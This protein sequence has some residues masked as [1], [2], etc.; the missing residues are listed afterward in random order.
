MI[1][2]TN[3]SN[4]NI[5]LIQP[6]DR[7]S[8]ASF[9]S[10]IEDI[11]N[12]V[13]GVS[14]LTSGAHFE[15]WT[16]ST[17]YQ[18]GD[19][20]RT[21]FLK[22]NQYLECLVGGTSGSSCPTD[23]IQGTRITDNDI[24]WVIKALG[25]VDTSTVSLWASNW[26]YVRGHI[27]M[28]NNCLYRCKT[29]H[30]SSSSFDLDASYWQEVKASVGLW[31]PLVY[32]YVDDI[33]V[34]DGLIYKNN[35]A[36]VS[37]STFSS[38]EEV[39]WELIGGAGGI[40]SWQSSETYNEGQLVINGGI[41]Y[42]VKSK[43]TSSSNFSADIANWDILNAGLNDW[44]TNVYYPVGIVVLANNKIYQCKSAHTSTTF[45]A[46]IANW[47]E[48]SGYRIVIDDWKA[49]TEY[50]VGDLCANDKKIYRC[51]IKHTSG[52]LFDSV[53][54][55]NWEEL[56]PT[57]NEIT[58][59][60]SN[61]SYN[62]KDIVI[63][64]NRLYRC[65]V[66]HTSSSAGF[67]QDISNWD[68]VSAQIPAWTTATYYGVGDIIQSDNVMY[69]CITAHTSTTDLAID[70]ANWT[71]FP[72]STAYIQDWESKA[73]YE[74]NQVIN[75]KG[76]LFRCV[77][78]NNDTNFTSTNW[79]KL[80][81]GDLSLWETKTA[82][83]LGDTVIY[84]KKL[85][86]CTVP[87]TS[88]DFQK[89]ISNWEEISATRI[90]DWAINTPYVSGDLVI[91]DK[92]IYRCTSVHVSNDFSKEVHNWELISAMPSVWVSQSPY[93][94]GDI[95]IVDG[96]LYYCKTA[97]TST[98]DIYT[99]MANWT[100]LSQDGT[101]EW[102]TKTYYFKNQLVTRDGTL[103]RANVSH[104]ST[105]FKADT[106]KWDNMQAQIQS[107]IPSKFYKKD[108]LV[109]QDNK[110]WK[111]KVDTDAKKFQMTK[112]FSNLGLLSYSSSVGSSGVH[113]FSTPHEDIK[114][115]GS[116]V[117]I[118]KL[119]ISLRSIF[120]M[121]WTQIDVYI[122]SDN[123]EY[124]FM[125]TAIIDTSTMTGSVVVDS[126]AQYIKLSAK[127]YHTTNMNGSAS[128][129]MSVSELDIYADGDWEQLYN[130]FPTLL[131]PWTSH[132]EY[133]QDELVYHENLVYRVKKGFTSGAN[134]D[135]T[136]LELLN[137]SYIEDWQPDKYY[138]KNQCVTKDDILLRSTVSHTS[139][140]TF[141]STEESQWEYILGGGNNG[142]SQWETAIKYKEGNVVL[143][144]NTPYISNT[145]HTS[146]TFADDF[147]KWDLTYSN[148][149]DWEPDVFYH[150][151]SLVVHNDAIFQANTPH[152]SSD[153][154]T[155]IGAVFQTTEP[156]GYDYTAISP[157]LVVVF[158]EET[159]L[160]GFLILQSEKT[161]TNGASLTTVDVDITDSN[162]V[163]KTVKVTVG[164]KL[165]V[166]EK[167]TS[168]KFKNPVGVN[169]SVTEYVNQT[170]LILVYGKDVSC[171]TSLINPNKIT[172]KQ[173][174]VLF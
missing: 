2:A 45:T 166:T 128:G 54:E 56:S 109:V 67:S 93:Q 24:T 27:V 83:A 92:K 82:Y 70:R 164:T 60:K 125:G 26:D 155:D 6:T 3:T 130:R 113:E 104:T 120:D 144:N 63:N 76:K 138:A 137:D 143:K 101:D 39:N 88:K 108:E 157:N 170:S 167:A 134:F 136:N 139:D 107:Y 90:S 18:K 123:V 28:Y 95:V 171:W 31:K 84:D 59:W 150:K 98:T 133:E 111:A 9:N 36:H 14:H 152:L 86:R 57:I 162:N 145:N 66:A 51:T 117:Y 156:Y 71:P 140:S 158:K 160:T 132:N 16:K 46:D 5:K 115:L 85:Y 172:K 124:T 34:N 161:R 11:D 112:Q 103:Y 126:T 43:H 4:L 7:F 116:S 80:G 106:S 102:K 38:T 12:K 151:G 25:V 49:N 168:I 146:N 153:F 61:T 13:V 20:V 62:A 48:I 35:I 58:D 114:D 21:P 129:E 15:V 78:A 47:Q 44:A 30:T 55:A 40:S 149:R 89:E 169:G 53:E 52:T 91:R 75:Y 41:V 110:L 42:K 22:S 122:S 165:E 148:I 33:V 69:K 154:D 17:S 10:V 1:L 99:D 19:V 73:S 118:N 147:Q 87:H 142:I 79:E 100:P 119:G 173:I 159:D 81:G 77:T 97:H 141:S 37:D 163:T 121:Y 96:R 29:P 74:P 8:D 50:V 127:S 131:R 23:N 64:D 174:D 32:Y 68:L 135:I 72:K 105:T 94:V 65:K